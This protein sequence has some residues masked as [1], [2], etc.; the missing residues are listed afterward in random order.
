MTG[1]IKNKNTTK[2]RDYLRYCVNLLR[3]K[4]GVTFANVLC[5]IVIFSYWAT[6]SFCLK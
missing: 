4:K 1:N 3:Y 5:N 2:T 6:M